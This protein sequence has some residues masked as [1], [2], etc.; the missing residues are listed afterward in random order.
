[1]NRHAS[2]LILLAVLPLG[3]SK[4]G[5]DNP[6]APSAAPSAAASAT[7]AALRT[8]PSATA[9]AAA[10]AASASASAA[11]EPPVYP[12]HKVGGAMYQGMWV[13]PFEIVRDKGNVGLSY[14]DAMNRCIGY[15][16]VLCTDAEWARACESDASLAKIETWTASGVGNNRF[17]TRG[18]DEAGCR[19][20]DTKEGTDLSPTRA[21]VC[22]DPNIGIKTGTKDALVDNT[23]KKL[24]AYQ[25]AM[26]DKDSLALAGLYED[27]VTWLGKER[28]NQDIIKVHEES[29]KK[30]PA[31]WTL[32]DTCSLAADKGASDGGA[33]AKVTADCLTLFQRKGSVVVAMQRLVFGGEGKIK[34]I[35]DAVTANVPSPDGTIVQ[36]KEL[37]ER[38]GILLS[39]D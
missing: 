5:G 37:K 16:K 21:A 3:C 30:D 14:L 39:A 34:L 1:M 36:E 24:F 9:S 20:R 31:Q 29:F 33:D 28:T 10:P 7:P 35:G 27:K 25:R 6:P 2:A 38:V 4:S 32:F 18:G 8:A 23:I 22:C 11:A 19:A 17:V 12:P 26:R 13:Q 15:G